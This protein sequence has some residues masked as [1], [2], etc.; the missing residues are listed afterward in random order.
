M[1]G[2]VIARTH[3]CVPGVQWVAGIDRGVFASIFGKAF[4]IK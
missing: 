3:Q 1:P 2:G 4:L